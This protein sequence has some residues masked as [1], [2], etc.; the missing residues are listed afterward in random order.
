MT[1]YFVN[2]NAQ[3]NGDHEVHTNTCIFLPT[4]HNRLD[5]GHHTTCVSAVRQARNTYPQSNG[6]QTCSSACH[7]Q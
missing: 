6:C 5:L 1:Q 2:S 4:L 7:T 3:S